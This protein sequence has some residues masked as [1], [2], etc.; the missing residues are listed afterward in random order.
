MTPF[1]VV[2]YLIIVFYQISFSLRPAV[3]SVSPGSIVR[4]KVFSALSFPVVAVSLE[5]FYKSNMY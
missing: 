1:I 5:V 3:S 2:R 4:H